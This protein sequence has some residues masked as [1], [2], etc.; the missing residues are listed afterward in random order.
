[1]MPGDF[2]VKCPVCSD[3][4]ALC[5]YCIKSRMHPIFPLKREHP[6]FDKLFSIVQYLE[7]LSNDFEINYRD[8][9]IV[10]A[11]YDGGYM[12]DLELAAG[13]IRRVIDR[14]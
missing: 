8:S 5:S 13:L 1:M 3:Q 6:E 10:N 7:K 11:V 4:N 12:R 9:K 14:D 2:T